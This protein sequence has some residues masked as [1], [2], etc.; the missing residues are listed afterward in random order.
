MKSETKCTPIVAFA[1]VFM[2]TSSTLSQISF[3][4][5]GQRYNFK[6]GIV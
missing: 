6:H 2:V 1:T 4:M 5:Q 3:K